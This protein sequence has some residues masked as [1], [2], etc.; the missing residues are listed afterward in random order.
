MKRFTI[1]DAKQADLVDYLAFLGHYPDAR[2]SR[3][4]EF[5]YLSPLP[6][7]FEKSPSFKVDRR[8]GLW[9][10]HGIGKGGS[11]IDF[12]MLYH[13]C[14]IPDLLDRLQTFVSFHRHPFQ[15]PV[16]KSAVEHAD[17]SPSNAVSGEKKK[18][19]VLSAGSIVSPALIS[20]LEQRKI[21]LTL[22]RRYCREV[23]YELNDKKYYAV[24]FPNDA[25]GYELRNVYFKGSSAPK[26]IT[27]F[28]N[29][30]DT[31]CVFEGFFSFLSF[32]AIRKHQ[33]LTSNILV[34]NSLSFFDKSCLLMEQHR[35][36]N[37]YLDRDSAGVKCTETAIKACLLYKDCSS[38][39]QG[40]KDLNEWLIKNSTVREIS[41]APENEEQLIKKH[42]GLSR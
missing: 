39:Y 3:E 18:I 28:D 20:Y 23:Q 12:G 7:R 40:S 22:A 29:K 21:P 13:N 16:T 8:K 24:G 11:I 5:W 17:Q 9:Y 33:P 14:N 4:H 34:L 1:A 31:V 26:S 36:I 6:G 15:I 42:R 38:L 10:D 19:R 37:L 30:A 32:A 41:N 2:M 35:E 25:G 27:L